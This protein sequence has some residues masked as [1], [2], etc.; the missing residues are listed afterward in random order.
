M[1]AKNAEQQ[2]IGSHRN[3]QKELQFFHKN[4]E[5]PLKNLMNCQVSYLGLDI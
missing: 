1:V 2:A 4:S 5:E 3:K